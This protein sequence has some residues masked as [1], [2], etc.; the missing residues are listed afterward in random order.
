MVVHHSAKGMFGDA[1]LSVNQVV[2]QLSC[3]VQ[4]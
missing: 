3:N 4:E 1:V 2:R